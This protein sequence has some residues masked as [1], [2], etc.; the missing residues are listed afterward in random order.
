MVEVELMEVHHKGVMV[1]EGVTL[2]GILDLYV[3]Y[4]E[5]QDTLSLH[6]ISILIIPFMV[7]E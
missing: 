4:A 2:E 7:L 6:V 3:K 1:V 5:S